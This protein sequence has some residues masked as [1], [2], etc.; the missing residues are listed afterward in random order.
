LPPSHPAPAGPRQTDPHTQLIRA[1]TL[2]QIS[3]SIIHEISQ[4]LAAILGD[5]EAT[6]RLIDAHGDLSTI[7]D[8]LTDVIASVLRADEI[9]KRMRAMLYDGE[10]RR[11][12]VDLNA[13]ARNTLRL[14]KKNLVERGVRV[15]CELDDSVDH[16][17]ADPIQ[18]E[19]VLLNLITN[20]CD[21]MRETSPGSRVVRISTRPGSDPGQVEL[22]VAD[23]GVGIAAEDCE[24]VFQPFVTGK[25]HGLG[26]GLA[27]SRLIVSAHGGR[28]WVEPQ[29]RGT[30]LRVSLRAVSAP[31]KEA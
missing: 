22:A 4:P 15:E 3:G 14:M 5:V 7:R 21:A 12:A 26:L 30:V 20:A 29:E 24:R 28:V 19:Q 18:I 11:E 8:I 23:A 6:V 2:G 10:V 13:V 9:I 25:Q 31:V 27:I 17:E 1:A 16:V